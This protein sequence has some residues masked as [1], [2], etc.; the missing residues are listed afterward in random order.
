MTMTPEQIMESQRMRPI[1]AREFCR[2]ACAYEA[3]KQHIEKLAEALDTIHM[4]GI[5][6]GAGWIMVPKV[7]WE[8][9]FE[10]VRRM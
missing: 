8:Q 4:H 7:E 6:A 10:R 2:G 1:P 9:A 5:E 3:L